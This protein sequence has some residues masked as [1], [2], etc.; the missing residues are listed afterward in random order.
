VRRRAE[1][2]TQGMKDDRAKAR[3]IYDYVVQ[4]TRYVALEFGIHG[5]KPYRVDKVL[6]RRFGDCKDKA[7][8]ITAMLKVAGVDT[9]LV[10]LRMRSLGQLDPQPASLAA[11]NHAI[12]YVPK[13][14]LYL[15]GTAEFHGIHEMPGADRQADVLIV[16][17]DA[18]SRFLVTPE[19]KSA[20]NKTTI[21]LNVTLAG[22]GSADA[23][24]SIETRGEGAPEF[25]RLYQAPATRRQSFEQ[26]W[27]QSFPG[28]TVSKLDVTDLTKLEEPVKLD[29]EMFTPRYAEAS[30]SFMR[31]YPFGAS[32]AYTQVLAPLVERKYDVVFPEAWVNVFRSKYRLPAE[33]AADAPP[34]K[35]VVAS[36][37]GSFTLECTNDKELACEGTMALDVARVS[38]KDY[39]K[40]RQ[41]LLKVD[42]VFSR[43]LVARKLATTGQSDTRSDEATNARAEAPT[44]ANEVRAGGDAQS[45]TEQKKDRGG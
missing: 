11:F 2:L 44:G 30:Q 24:G 27:A 26:A 22:N 33:W 31:F 6:A 21:E 5:F 38:A 17:P 10:L 16:E 40:F 45:N 7:S 42:Q 23:K 3:A 4:K 13:L 12:A 18:A 29:F 37:F 25:R 41:W 14:D 19:A 39:P 32:R 8:L 35:E 28:L 1:A 43:K 15:D 9:R 36:E 20:E 34:A